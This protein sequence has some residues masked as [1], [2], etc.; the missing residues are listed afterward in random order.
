VIDFASDE[1]TSQFL[2]RRRRILA[3]GK[4]AI[5]HLIEATRKP[6]YLVALIIIALAA[7]ETALIV[8]EPPPRVYFKRMHTP[9]PK[10]LGALRSLNHVGLLPQCS[11]PDVPTLP[12][13]RILT[14]PDAFSIWLPSPWTRT[15]LD[16]ANSIFG[17]PSATFSDR[18][19]NYLRVSRVAEGSVG[20]SFIGNARPTEEC[21]ISKGD[22]GS[23]WLFYTLRYSDSDV[24]YEAMADAMTTGGRR[25]KLDVNSWSRT[26][27]DSLVSIASKA[28]LNQ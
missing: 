24:R 16:T 23:I 21:E 6:N 7:I 1:T 19:D 10:D 17:D 4:Q 20:R 2:R 26:N 11:L 28:I 27:R 18:R 25:Y 3:T 13:W 8:R 14:G 5:V 22:A 9:E 12:K 15:K